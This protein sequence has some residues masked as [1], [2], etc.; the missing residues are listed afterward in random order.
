[1]CSKN[2]FGLSSI[3][4][5]LPGFFLDARLALGPNWIR[6]EEK[7]E[8]EKPPQPT[9]VEKGKKGLGNIIDTVR[10]EK[11]DFSLSDIENSLKS[12]TF[13]RTLALRLL[14]TINLIIFNQLYAW[15]RVRKDDKREI[16]RTSG[17]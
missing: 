16:Q 4:N 8:K 12:L 14:E 10:K 17:V 3:R 13:T 15:K 11:W 5:Y 7:R 6:K 2:K 9:L 1:M